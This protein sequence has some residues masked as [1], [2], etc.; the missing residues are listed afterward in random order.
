MN[1]NHNLPSY[2]LFQNVFRGFS[3]LVY[4]GVQVLFRGFFYFLLLLSHVTRSLPRLALTSVWPKK[5]EKLPLFCRSRPLQWNTYFMVFSFL[6]FFISKRMVKT[7]FFFNYHINIPMRR[8][9]SELVESKS[10]GKYCSII[11]RIGTN[12]ALLAFSLGM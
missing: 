3:I 5:V 12:T 1:S 8:F 10:C 7:N 4:I 9:F 2:S 6:A 11:I